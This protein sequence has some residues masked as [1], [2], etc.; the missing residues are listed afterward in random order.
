[1]RSQVPV[2]GSA[3]AGRLVNEPPKTVPHGAGGLDVL[4][5]EDNPSDR[6]LYAEVLESRGHRVE[7]VADTDSAWAAF[8][9]RSFPLVLL[10]LGLPGSM[11]GLD[12]CRR[13]RGL[14]EGDR[15]VVLVVT[16]QTEPTTLEEVLDAGADDY[17][18]K[19]VDVALLSIRLAVAERSVS[20][21]EERARA[22]EALHQASQRLSTLFNNLG[23]VFFSAELDP[24]RLLQ[25]SPAS[26]TVLGVESEEL[27]ER[28][29]GWQDLLL[30]PEARSRLGSHLGQAALTADDLPR[31][32]V[33]H[34]YTVRVDGAER[35]VQATYRITEE[36]GGQTTRVDGMVADV[37]DR[38]R[39]QVELASRNRE[40]E[41]LARIS[42]Q[43][44]SS[45]GS[46][47]A[48]AAALDEVRRATG[49][50]IA[51][52]ERWH[53]QDR[54]LVLEMLRGLEAD[55]RTIGSE[56]PEDSPSRV[57]VSGGAPRSFTDPRDF[58]RRIHPSLR[59]PE[60]RL[61]LVFPLQRGTEV[62]GT[63]SLL[64]TEPA[65]PDGGLIRLGTALA[66]SLAL[67]MAHLEL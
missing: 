30:P 1:M 47:E 11:G 16:G 66:T 64:H 56:G 65:R 52:L 20:R 57:V 44:L 14:P 41:A 9:E 50:P 2:R 21:Q 22:R 37:S 58:A 54:R 61:L 24:D 12:L 34:L 25:V 15:T 42:E 13:I 36:R 53:P 4:L 48:L 8:Q 23:D 28:N 43:I 63:L 55:P 49:F 67:H 59:D 3:N 18:E 26:G 46:A 38:R 17:V 10:D 40:L 19:P 29:E 45:P 6:W 31:H 39:A 60:P 7:A 27:L 35:W 62:L 32:P 5:V 33:V 51:Y